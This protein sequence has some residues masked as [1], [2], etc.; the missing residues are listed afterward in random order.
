MSAIA[1]TVAAGWP[2]MTSRARLG[3]LK[4]PMMAGIVIGK[5]LAGHLGHTFESSLFDAFGE[6]Q[7]RRLGRHGG[8]RPGQYLSIPVGWHPHHEDLDAV[9]GSFQ[10]AGGR[11][12]VREFRL[13]EGN[14]R[15][16][17]PR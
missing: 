2:A 11:Q 3:P 13:R 12:A 15:C 7:N 8:S 14:A 9:Q 4:T 10:I 16:A 17:V 6:A 1:I 5:L